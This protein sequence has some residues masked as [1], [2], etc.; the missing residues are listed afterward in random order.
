MKDVR[1]THIGGPT[2]LIEVGGWRILTDPTFDP[3]GR[4][5]SFGWGTG[6]RK[7]TGPARRADDLGP[8]DAVLLSHDHH[9]DNLD[10]AGRAVLAGV[11]VLLTTRAGARRLAGVSADV[12][13]LRP[14]E[15]SVLRAPGRAPISVTATPCRHGPPLSRP[16]V[17]P[18][19]GFA[20]QWPGQEH[21]VLWVTGD[22]VLA[23]ALREVP[24]RLA[25]DT[26]LLHL[27]GVR[28]PLTGPI[29][30]SL[31][32]R[33]AVELCALVRPRTII[34]VHYEGW[35]HFREGRAEVERA[36]AAAPDGLGDRLRWLPLPAGG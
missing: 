2:A 25:V 33:R 12:R 7:R 35:E 14:W 32:G 18:V 31:T 20:L 28:F 17:G 30:Y 23:P 1:V 6:S 27:G 29:R 5:Y 26:V 9:A 19:V 15:E 3:P 36:F 13:G 16:I 21:G 10:E 4:R 24:R 11:P 22:T 34:P 8:I